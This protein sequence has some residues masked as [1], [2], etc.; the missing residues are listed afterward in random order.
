M[1]LRA[2]KDGAIEGNAR[3][4]VAGFVRSARSAGTACAGTD[5]AGTACAI[6][7]RPSCARPFLCAG[8][9]LILDPTGTESGIIRTVSATGGSIWAAGY[10][11]D[12][13]ESRV[14]CLWE[15]GILMPLTGDACSAVAV[16]GGKV[17]A[18]GDFAKGMTRKACVW[19]DGERTELAGW[20]SQAVALC[21][22]GDAFY[23]AGCV[24][25][26]ENG[27]KTLPCYWKNADKID[28]PVPDVGMANNLA[29]AIA[30]A[31][32]SV[33]VAGHYEAGGR[34]VACLWRDGVRLDLDVPRSGSA[35]ATSIAVD[36]GTAYVGGYYRDGRLL[37]PC[38][39]KEGELVRLQSDHRRDSVLTALFARDGTVY[40]A[41][42][43]M[44][45]RGERPCYWAGRRRHDVHGASS[46]MT[47]RATSIIVD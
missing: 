2:R 4:Q 8:Y 6:A 45:E 39:W 15:G 25:G 27:S 33:I 14:A 16:S 13:E 24:T 22:D 19:V 26:F 40:G 43:R 47:G 1:M 46:R 36:G 38:Y 37:V 21:L 34:T 31:G 17:Y 5:C 7:D 28:L 18:A 11:T 12:G 29:T 41:G 32:G 3:V 20:F 30:V 35:F 44:D 9:S 10:Y 23:A 42:Y